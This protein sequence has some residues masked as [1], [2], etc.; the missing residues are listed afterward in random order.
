M[1][2]S[3][4]GKVIMFPQRLLAGVPITSILPLRGAAPWSSIS[5]PTDLIG[6]LLADPEIYSLYITWLDILSE[7]AWRT[8][9]AQRHAGELDQW[10]RTVRG[11]YPSAEFDPRILEHCGSVAQRMLHPRDPVLA[12]TQFDQEGPAW[13]AVSNVH[14]LPIAVTATIIEQDTLRLARPLVIRPREH[15]KP[16]TY[17]RL[18]L[19]KKMDRNTE[20]SLLTVVVGVEHPIVVASRVRST[21]IADK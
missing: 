1:P 12:Y 9:L 19:S 3:A 10:G 13:I 17:T 5:P 2:D 21:F 15:G 8:Q 4:S 6:K 16:L 14:D 11:D 20:V 7:P 18:P